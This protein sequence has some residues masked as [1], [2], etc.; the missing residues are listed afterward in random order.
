MFYNSLFFQVI[1]AGVA[2]ALVVIYVEP[3]FKNI[4]ELQSQIDRY[5]EEINK[6]NDTNTL[7]RNLASQIEEIPEAKQRALLTYMPDKIDKVAVSRD[8]F[9]LAEAAGL[10]VE[11][12]KA[13]EK[14]TTNQIQEVSS[15]T[16]KYL[17]PPVPSK[18]TVNLKGGY[19]D[20][21]VFLKSLE[22]SNYPLEIGNLDVSS[23]GIN[24]TQVT[25]QDRANAENLNVNIDIITYSHI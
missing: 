4:G 22:I 19:E 18:F 3:T 12:I 9:N 21:K 11:G 15:L 10:E 17:T 6:I 13:E 25:A 20:L 1:L 23:P 16:E 7:L 8:I 5:Q 14:K 2:L 24:Q